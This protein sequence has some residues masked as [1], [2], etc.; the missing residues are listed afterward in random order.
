MSSEE[1]K[2][3]LDEKIKFSYYK[4]TNT[5]PELA[6][7]NE[8]NLDGIFV[9]CSPLWFEANLLSTRSL[10]HRFQAKALKIEI[11]L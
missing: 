8:L 1:Y 4:M 2:N 5:K 10:G 9:F 7:Q 6:V 3:F 11:D